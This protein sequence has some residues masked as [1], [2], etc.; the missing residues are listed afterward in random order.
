[1]Y[2]TFSFESVQFDDQ[3]GR[4]ELCYG[5]GEEIQ[6]KEVVQLPA[7]PYRLKPGDSELEAA[8]FN[9]HLIGGISYYK[10]YCPEELIVKSGQL[11]AGQAQ[12]WNQVYINGLGEFFYRNQLDFRDKI[13]FPVTEQMPEPGSRQLEWPEPKKVLV[14]FGGGKDSLVTTELLKEHEISGTLFRVGPHAVI[15]QLAGLTGWPMLT[16]ERNIDPHLF[17]L[18]QAGA[19]NGH[20]PISAFISFLAI[21]VA[22]LLDYDAV[23]MSNE[24]SSNLGNVE[25]LGLNINHQWS[26][27]QEFEQLFQG[28][29]AQYITQ[30]VTYRNP[31]R[32]LSELEITQKLVQYPQYLNHLSSCNTNWKLLAR[33]ASAKPLWC[34]QCPK[35]AFVFALFTAFLPLEQVSQIF[36]ANL[37]ESQTLLPTYR[38]LFGLE[39][40]KPLECVGTPNEMAAALELACQQPAVQSTLVAKLYLAEVKPLFKERPNLVEEVMTNQPT[41]DPWVS[42]L[43]K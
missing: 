28:Y 11:S 21:L 14:P 15:E 38:E 32:P 33:E 22:L 39:G 43:L 12:F 42:A 1:M 8:L 6:F 20:V 30:S 25:Y 41:A 16:V 36:G 29:V 5:L 7:G 40:I 17:E 31:L 10:T 24:Q 13:Q 9:L 34:G 19:L 2:K 37:F 23:I 35:C 3:T 26:K 27:S 4:V 18:N